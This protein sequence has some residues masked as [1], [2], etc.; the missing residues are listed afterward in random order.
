M[1]FSPFVG[2]HSLLGFVLAW[3][4]QLNFPVIW[5]GSHLINNPW[6]MVPVYSAGYFFGD[7]LLQGI[8]GIDSMSM[9]PAWM[10]AINGYLSKYI[11]MRISLCSF[12]V[13][14]N[15]LGM[16]IGCTL[17]PFTKRLF[18]RLSLAQRAL[19]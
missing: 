9:N 18:M 5:I 4:F 11:G 1:G 7:W 10:L 6:T 12:L 13:G 3:A 15:L 14:G 17:Y 8:C 2:L 16:I 19:T